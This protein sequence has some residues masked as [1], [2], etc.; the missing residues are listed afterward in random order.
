MSEKIIL[1]ARGTVTLPS[2]LRQ[3]L[4]LHQGDVLEVE[5]KDGLLILKPTTSYPVRWY[6]DQEVAAW[7]VADQ[8]SPEDLKRWEKRFP[9][10]K[11]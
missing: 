11:A 3:K 4:G 5:E 7:T 2:K 9:T 6:S 10:P 8:M 1:N